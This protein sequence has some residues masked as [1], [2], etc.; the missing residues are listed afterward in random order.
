MKFANLQ[1][2][3]WKQFAHVDVDFH[4]K[5]TILT[6]ANG[7]GKTTIL[8]L[9]SRHFG[10][11]HQELATPAKDTTSGI[12]S[13]FSR[14][15]WRKPEQNDPAIGTLKYN[16]NV[17]AP[18]TIP[19]NKQ[20]AAQY[21]IAVQNQ[22]AVQ[23]F[24]IQSHRP[25]FTYQP[26]TQ[27]STK[28]RAK[29]QAFQLVSNTTRNWASSSGQKPANFYIKETLLTWAIYGYGN[30]VITADTEQ[31]R[32]YEGFQ[33]ILREIL[34]ATLGFERLGIRDSEVVLETKTGEF[35]IDAV[36]GGVSALI[37]LAWQVYMFGTTE[38]EPFVVVI[39]EIENH[40]HP[41]MQRDILPDLVRVFPNCQFVVATH[42]PLVVGSLRDSTVYALRYGENRR[43]Y[44]HR[45]D[46]KEMAQ[47]ATDVLREVLGVPVTIPRW[48]E[49]ELEIVANEFAKREINDQMLGE[50]RARLKSLG[51]EDLVPETVARIVDNR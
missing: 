1:L 33:D 2:K 20:G 27:L 37:D 8:N 6:G 28:K 42:S 30:Q 35:M 44:A 26:V 43:V 21:Q 51:F 36:S 7:S 16:N 38:Q 4:P 22:Q 46:L 12:V 34:P 29:K 50:L 39:D 3:E 49:H 18:L 17:T 10:Y 5:L 14:L 32:F 40:L 47:T 24:F 9:L 48:A 45:L 25:V 19:A 13:F 11:S 15:F 23:G 41:A 31:L